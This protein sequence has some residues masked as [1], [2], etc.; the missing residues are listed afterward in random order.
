MGL[1]RDIWHT[2]HLRASH[3][4]AHSLTRHMEIHKPLEDRKK[5]VCDWVD[6]E[7]GEVCGHTLSSAEGMKVH[8]VSVHTRV[9]LYECRFCDQTFTTNSGWHSH[10]LHVHKVSTDGR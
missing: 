1:S 10:E 9:K 8:K 4:H 5:F 6:P 2:W 3:P 7:T